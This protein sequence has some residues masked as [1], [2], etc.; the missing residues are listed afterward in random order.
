MQTKMEDL[1]ISYVGPAYDINGNALDDYAIAKVAALERAND[2]FRE[3][4]L[5]PAH[6]TQLEAAEAGRGGG[7]GG[8]VEKE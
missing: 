8:A 7:A 4:L 2:F 6:P 3:C 5:T 1:I